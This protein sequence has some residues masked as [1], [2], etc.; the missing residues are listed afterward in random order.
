[1]LKVPPGANAA[2]EVAIKQQ[3][4]ELL[5]RLEAGESFTQL[6]QKYS[7]GPQAGTGGDLGVITRGGGLPQSLEQ[8][9]FT[10][11]S[12]SF[13]GPVRTPFG[14]HI[15]KILSRKEQPVPKFNELRPQLEMQLRQ[16]TY[17]K[18]LALWIEELK[19]EAFIEKRLIKE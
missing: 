15:I 16:K 19:G 6:A 4:Q 1:M 11:G 7:Q 10:L 14:Y 12:T 3:A 5:N 8:A 9:F 18:E 2:Q 17:Q 13:G